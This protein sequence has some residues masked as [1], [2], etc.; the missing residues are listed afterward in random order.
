L[1][2]LI[3]RLSSMTD[4]LM[5]WLIVFGYIGVKALQKRR[6]LVRNASNVGESCGSHTRS[7]QSGREIRIVNWLNAM[8]RSGL[9]MTDI[10]KHDMYQEVAQ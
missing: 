5:L 6:T 1:T 10:P 7:C 2:H 3:K 8:P 9:I 4:H